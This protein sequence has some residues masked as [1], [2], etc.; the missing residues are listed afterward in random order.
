M[1]Y[2]TKALR[3][4]HGFEFREAAACKELARGNVVLGATS[5]STTQAL[6]LGR[7]AEYGRMDV[8]VWLD[9]YGAHA[10]Y[11]MGKRR[12]GKTFTLGAIVEGLLGIDGFS[13]ADLS[14]AVVVFDTMN[15]FLTARTPAMLVEPDPVRQWGL[16]LAETGQIDLLYPAGSPSPP[17][18]VG[19]N[20]FSVPASAFTV[21]D[22]CDLFGL[23]PFVAPM[24]Q[25]VG[26][27]VERAGALGFTVDGVNY[28]AS[29]YDIERLVFCI[30][31]AD[32]LAL[33]D[34]A[35]RTALARRFMALNRTGLF[36]NDET[37]FVRAGWATIFL[38]RDIE[39]AL[40]RL[41][42]T[43]LTSRILRDRSST[44]AS[45]RMLPVMRAKGVDT[46]DC[47]SSIRSGTPRTWLI[48]DEA[49]NYIPSIG[50][51]TCR[52]LLNRYITEGRNLG[53]SIVVATQHPSALD[54]ALKR[55]ADILL[56]HTL[57]MA[58]DIDAASNMLTTAIPDSIVFDNVNLVSNKNAKFAEA[59]RRMPRGYCLLSSDSASRVIP[60]AVRPRVTFHGGAG[61]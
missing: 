46:S 58:E 17:D 31:R 20:S 18:A 43:Y 26:D 57:T 14:Q 21:E 19:A 56:I 5:D 7:L 30:T 38:L 36:G 44:E 37:Q 32:E 48:I 24:G 10:I 52:R 50:G 29:N 33:Y 11:V 40:R 59:I 16:P 2:P 8:N 13:T 12:S 3:L 15:V 22:W 42:V 6:W 54:P 25:L 9:I 51:G 45:E 27:A 47:E 41:L 34:P 60:V 35:T 23:D 61:Y 4:A 1:N 55:N 53:L 49:H 28:K 39:P